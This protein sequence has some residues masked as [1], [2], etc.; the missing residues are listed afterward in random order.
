MNVFNS[1]WISS[2][3]YKQFQR[4]AA[5]FALEAICGPPNRRTTFWRHQNNRMRSQ[6]NS[7]RSRGILRAVPS[8]LEADDSAKPCACFQQ[9][10]DRM[11]KTKEH[12]DAH[13]YMPRLFFNSLQ[14][15]N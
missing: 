2:T 1:F 4:L 10:A 9:L 5:N 15:S 11:M 7:V 6:A 12:R 8:G 14:I 3:G 13:P